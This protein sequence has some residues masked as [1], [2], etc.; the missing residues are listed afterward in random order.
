MQPWLFLAAAFV[1]VAFGGLMA[2]VDAALG[3]SSRAD[4]TDLA[5][6]S[7]ARRSLLAIADDPGAHVNAVN[8]VR[9]IA[10]TTAAVLV[11]LAFTMCGYALDEVLNPRIRAR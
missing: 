3:V 2:A 8:F 10:E 11:T 1:L 6:G 7:R 4:V 5:L 9:I